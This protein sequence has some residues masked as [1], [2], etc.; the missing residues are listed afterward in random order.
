MLGIEKYLGNGFPSCSFSHVI[1]S[2]YIHVQ[3]DVNVV[4]IQFPKFVFNANAMRAAGYGIHRYSAFHFDK[5]LQNF[6]RVIR[7]NWLL[8]TFKNF[9]IPIRQIKLCNCFASKSKRKCSIILS[10]GTEETPGDTYR[11][12]TSVPTF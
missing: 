12:G 6:T 3:V 2:I 9:Q 7:I 5:T 1:S 4:Q 10:K 11:G 8:T